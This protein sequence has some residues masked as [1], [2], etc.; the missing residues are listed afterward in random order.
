MANKKQLPAPLTI[1]MLV[2]ILAAIATWL[3]PA[4]EVKRFP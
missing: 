1:L 4:A 3:K 2:V